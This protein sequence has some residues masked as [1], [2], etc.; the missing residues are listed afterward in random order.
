[1]LPPRVASI[2]V[3]VVACGITV[4]STAEERK[5]IVDSCK[6]LV[7]Q[8]EAAGLRAEG[9]YRDNYSPGWKFN[10]WELKVNKELLFGF[11]YRLEFWYGT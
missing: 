2:Q 7:E 9:D 4:A 5:S 10:H 8:L 1:M 11:I 6:Q 3:I